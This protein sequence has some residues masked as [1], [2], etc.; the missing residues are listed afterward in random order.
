MQRFSVLI[1]RE[2]VRSN[3]FTVVANT[4]DE[5]FD[6]AVKALQLPRALNLID[7]GLEDV[8]DNEHTEVVE[9][10]PFDPDEGEFQIQIHPVEQN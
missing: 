6:L 10:T 8:C 4:E 2:I 7:K 5:A 9:V 1:S 3:Y